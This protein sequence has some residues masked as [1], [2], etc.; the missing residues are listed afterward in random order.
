MHETPKVSFIIP[1]F[2]R[3]HELK[4]SLASC[5][6][7]TIQGWEAIVVDDHSDQADL[8]KIVND[9]NDSRIRYF[10]QSNGRKGEAAARETAIDKASSDIFITLDSDDIS[11]PNRAARCL[12]VLKG[13][14]PK[15]LYSRVSHFSETNPIGKIKSTFQPFSRKLLEMY[16]FITNPGTAFNRSAYVR[17]GSYYDLNLKLATDYEQFLRMSQSGVDIFG[18]DEVHV[19]YRKHQGAA[20]SGASSEMHRAIMQIRDKLNIEAFPLKAIS[21]YALP[22]IYH[23]ILNDPKQK[24]LWTDERWCD[25]Q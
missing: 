2:N 4:S 1:A 18:I 3:P 12:D 5:L 24:S 6:A 10:H 15:L 23:N 14:S 8:Q 17:A 20:T 7:Q 25:L 13:I 9:F 16:N 21:E 11:Y 19:L 22:E